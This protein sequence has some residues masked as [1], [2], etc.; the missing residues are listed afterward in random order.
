MI[1]L[2]ASSDLLPC[3]VCHKPAEL[4]KTAEGTDEHP[5]SGC[6][7][8]FCQDSHCAGN[9]VPSADNEYE[10]VV[11]W[12]SFA[13]TLKYLWYKSCCPNCGWSEDTAFERQLQHPV[14]SFFQ[15]ALCRFRRDSLPLFVCF[16]LN[17]F[18]MTVVHNVAYLA[19]PPFWPVFKVAFPLTL[20]IYLLYFLLESLLNNV[21]SY[22]LLKYEAK[23]KAEQQPAS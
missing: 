9:C 18:W 7:V 8:V 11:A 1:M 23:L 5:E 14:Y 13:S 6:F 10:A 22:I 4:H 21:E 16:F 20:G 17:Y 3:P 12:N 15:R 2:S 19:R